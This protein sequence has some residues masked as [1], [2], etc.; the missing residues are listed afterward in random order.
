[1][2]E[3]YGIL[4]IFSLIAIGFLLSYS[5]SIWEAIGKRREE[6]K[7]RIEK[8]KGE[9]ERE[10]REKQREKERHETEE[11][12]ERERKRKEAT[13]Q[14]SVEKRDETEAFSFGDLRIIPE[15]R[16][17]FCEGGELKISTQHRTDLVVT[18]TD[19]D[20]CTHEGKKHVDLEVRCLR[21]NAAVTFEDWSQGHERR[22]I[23]TA[24]DGT[25]RFIY[26]NE[27]T[28][29]RVVRRTE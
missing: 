21:C 25:P 9:Q 18:H 20:S 28:R 24:I 26:E 2:L 10:E 3:K 27:K 8:E 22:V 4:I 5:P 7:R 11:K 1:M 17:R 16:C 13:I 23:L 15:S 19:Y 29:L 12:A 14:I 6:R